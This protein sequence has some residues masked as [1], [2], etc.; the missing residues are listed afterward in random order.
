MRR[1]LLVAGAVIGLAILIGAAVVGYAFLNLNSIIA[2]N[3]ARLL[4]RATAAVGRPLEVAEIK[5]SLGWGTA[6]DVTG[7]QL[8]NDAAFSQLPFV[9]A[10]EVLLKVELLPLLRKEIKV[11]ELI[12]RRPQIRIIRSA[13]GAIN[14]STIAK[15]KR[16]SAGGNLMQPGAAPGPESSLGELSNEATGA[17]KYGRPQMSV[18]RSTLNNVIIETFTIEDGRI[19]Y[20]DNQAGGAPVTVNAVNLKVTH[21]SL[22]KPFDVA[23][24]LAAF[25]DHQ[26]LKVTGTAGPVIADGA[27]DAGAIPVNLDASVGPLTL[28]QLKSVPQLAQ[29][30]PHALAISGEIKL[31]ARATGTVDTISFDAAS[32]LS[33]NRVAYAPAFDKP[34]GTALEIALSGARTAGRIVVQQASLSLADLRAKLTDIVLAAGRMSAHVDSNRF[35]LGP[36]ASLIVPARRYNPA[37]AA[38]IHAGV[39]LANAK[40]VLDGTVTLTNVNAAMPNGETPPVSDLNGTIR[41][42]GSAANLGPLTFKLGSGNAQLEASADSLQPMHASYRLS[43]DKITL[44]ELMPSRSNAGAENL[45]QVSAT[46]TV[47]NAGGA[48]AGSTR[49]SATAGQLANVP[50]TA[51]A[52]DANYAGGRVNVNSLKFGAFE[53]TIGASGV[54]TIGAAPA[55]D[56]R[57]DA[58][59]VNMQAALDSQHSKAAN[60]IRGSL[61]GDIQIAGQGNGLDQVK[62]T[63]RGAGRA[64]MEHG[65]L[66]GVNVVAQALKK[67]NNVPGIGAL[68]PA[69]VV[70]NHPELFESPDTDIQE[71]SLIFAILGPRIISH[72][73]V[74]RST[75]YSIFAD[76]WFDL[77]KDLDLAARIVMSK[78]FS[79]ELVAARHN[80]SFLTN[81]D[82][83]VEIPLRVSGRLPQPAVAPDVGL[84]ARRAASHAVQG[85]VGELI[86]KNG[87]GGLL[88]KHGLGGLLGG[89]GGDTSGGGSDS[90]GAPGASPGATPGATG[91]SNGSGSV[92]NPFKGLFH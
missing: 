36:I 75:D 5:A 32:D 72:D 17:P 81:N 50:F 11:T 24:E 18:S 91:G 13:S 23:L 53:G 1:L 47:G 28:A 48:L 30:L 43:A 73:I 29:A 84:I 26:N 12:L 41:L 65:K 15:N 46:G 52:L 6:I 62:P 70:A 31:Q 80:A 85:R 67:V 87:L 71:A 49:L 34:A 10:D 76:G 86:Q 63:M 90:S 60:T 61:T 44:A 66:V 54:A 55:F 88:Q 4:D 9:Q 21:F 45:V 14:A 39:S 59:N 68:V 7:V 78:P 64:R 8:A 42:A 35:D 92:P 69:A 40:P 79:G 56:F 20:I 19:V 3:R 16:A 82:S 25:G 74:A 2:A 58:Q 57:I 77:D 51:L 89:L 27:I 38:E 37:G 33:S 83:E 22:A